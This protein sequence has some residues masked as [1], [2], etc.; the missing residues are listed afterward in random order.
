M[1]RQTNNSE[2]KA[3][4]HDEWETKIGDTKISAVKWMGTNSVCLVSSI[5]TS[6]ATQKCSRRLKRELKSP[7][8]ILKQI[9]K[10][11]W[12]MLICVINCLLTTAS[13]RRNT[14]RSFVFHLFD[15]TVVNCWLQYRRT[16]TA[17]E[18]PS[19]KQN[20][21]CEFKLRLSRSLMYDGKDVTRKRGRP[22]NDSACAQKRKTGRATK[23]IPKITARQCG[24]ISLLSMHKGAH[25]SC[26]AV[27]EKYRC[28]V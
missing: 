20:S 21:L 28:T 10:N 3:G 4:G 1:I 17:V 13:K 5:T 7:G 14:I 23:K 11:I 24:N 22:S 6:W 16:A 19:R 25:A 12:E 27:R 15:M 2:L 9:I 26:Q 8:P 18:V